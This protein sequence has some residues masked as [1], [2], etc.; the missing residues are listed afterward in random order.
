[1]D[2]VFFDFSWSNYHNDSCPPFLIAF[3]RF[4]W[5]EIMLPEPPKLLS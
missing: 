1:M 5:G 2:L 4:G 3:K